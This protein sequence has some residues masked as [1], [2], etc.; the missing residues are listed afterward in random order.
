M[1]V[2]TIKSVNFA[3]YKIMNFPIPFHTELCIL[4]PCYNNIDG[5]IKSLKSIEYTKNK[6]IIIVIDDGSAQPVT[7]AR[8]SENCSTLMNIKIIRAESNLGI[9][10]ALNKGL[11]FIYANYKPQFIA[12]LDCGDIC[13]YQRFYTQIAFFEA[14]PDIH[15]TGTWCYFKDNITGEAYRYNTPTTHRKIM[16]EMYFRNVFIH[17]TVMWRTSA[18]G[19]LKY[20]EQYPC[21]EDYGLFYEIVL[22]MKTA[23]IDEYLVICEINHKG[24]SLLNRVI[25][26]KSRRKV[27]SFYGNNK[28]LNLMAVFKLN[29]LMIIP[30]Q[31][32]FN[33]KKILYNTA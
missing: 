11:E 26:L 9:T 27:V 22:K 25:Q 4:I 15:L 14:N 24:I 3:H 31:L 12:R 7:L 21:A 5:L 30:Y 18:T 16:R 32:I 28:I 6:Y 33:T 17:P 29:C 8:I 1:P 23:I 19:N 2:L 20:P 10:K 13:N